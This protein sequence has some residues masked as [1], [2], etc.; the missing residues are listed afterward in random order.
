MKPHSHQ[1]VEPQQVVWVGLQFLVMAQLAVLVVPV[2]FQQLMA[3]QVL[4]VVPVLQILQLGFLQS[5]LPT[6]VGGQEWQQ[7]QQP[8]VT[9]V[10]F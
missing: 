8:P 10:A 3:Q 6:E 1:L 2:D 5:Y 4:S 7:L 9:Q